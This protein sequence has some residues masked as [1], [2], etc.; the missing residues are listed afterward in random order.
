MPDVGGR[1]PYRERHALALAPRSPGRNAASGE[2]FTQV[3]SGPRASRARAPS[4]ATP[5]GG[6]SEFAPLGS[7]RKYPRKGR[8]KVTDGDGLY[9]LANPAGGKYWYIKYYL[10]GRPQ[11]VVFGVYP[12][13]SLKLAREKRV[14]APLI[15]M[16]AVDHGH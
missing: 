16:C 6:D 5:T 8:Y 14:D 15:R 4:R 9:L 7:D 3:L 10:G 11:E 12:A 2:C 13:V 1:R